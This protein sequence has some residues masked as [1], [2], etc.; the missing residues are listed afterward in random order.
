MR[1][2]KYANLSDLEFLA[3]INTARNHSPII[4]ELAKR[5]EKE[6][7]PESSGFQMSCPVCEA[8]LDVCL[9]GTEV[10]IGIPK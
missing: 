7:Q 1:H 4:E 2:T 6:V 3:A 9:T 5:F 8:D 10:T